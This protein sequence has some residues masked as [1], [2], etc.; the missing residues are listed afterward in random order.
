V[1]PNLDAGRGVGLDVV[2]SRLSEMR[3]RLKVATA[4]GRYTEFRIQLAS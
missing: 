1:E 4:P 3:A 2:K